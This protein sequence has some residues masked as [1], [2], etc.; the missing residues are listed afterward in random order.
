MIE[1]YDPHM[2]VAP[3]VVFLQPL[4]M[5]PCIYV[6]SF[7]FKREITAVLFLIIYQIL[8]QWYIPFFILAIRTSAKTEIFGDNLF[9]FYKMVLPFESTGSTFV[10]NKTVLE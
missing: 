1:K 9:S 2:E 5:L 6:A 7:I 4:S 8:A 3:D 10:F